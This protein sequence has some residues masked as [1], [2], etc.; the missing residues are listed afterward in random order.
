MKPVV[1]IFLPIPALSLL[2]AGS[3]AA[4]VKVTVAH[5]VLAAEANGLA[6]KNGPTPRRSDAAPAAK[7]TPLDG[8][9]DGNG[10]KLNVFH[11]REGPSRGG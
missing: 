10:C 9:R 7:F 2:L 11:Q 3:A 6:F 4:E 8:R 1:R 5:P